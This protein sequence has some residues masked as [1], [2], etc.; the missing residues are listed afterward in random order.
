MKPRTVATRLLATAMI[1]IV[2][3]GALT[4]VEHR[5]LRGYWW[6]PGSLVA[7]MRADRVQSIARLVEGERGE[8]QPTTEAAEDLSDWCGPAGLQTCIE[9]QTL[10]AL[11]GRNAVPSSTAGQL[12]GALWARLW[13]A[14]GAHSRSADRNGLGSPASGTAIQFT[15]G[16]RTYVWIEYSTHEVEDDWHR[17]VQLLYVVNGTDPDLVRS[18]VYR[19]EIAGFEDIPLWFLWGLNALLVAAVW[20]TRLSARG[21][22]SAR[23]LRLA[24]SVSVALLVLAGL[25]LA[26]L[27]LTEIH[28]HDPWLVVFLITAALLLSPIGSLVRGARRWNSSRPDVPI[29]P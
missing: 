26:T 21:T 23:P 15:S 27:T 12:D 11:F 17:D 16:G 28:R 7:D 3:G 14:V 29:N 1:A 20:E 13:S 22:D 9:G 10:L 8:L 25:G 4:L 5:V 6:R 18:R 2:T 19:Y 24:R